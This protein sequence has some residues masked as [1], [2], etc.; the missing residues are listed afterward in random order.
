MTAQLPPVCDTPLF[1]TPSNNP[2]ALQGYTI[3]R[4]F[5]TVIVLTQIHRQA[6]SDPAIH[7][8]RELLLRLRDGNVLHGDWQTL[9][10]RSPTLADNQQDFDDAIRLFYDRESVAKFNHHSS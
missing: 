7:E 10:Q 8:F 4:T 1:A 3:Y 6:G 5:S 9:L 2:L